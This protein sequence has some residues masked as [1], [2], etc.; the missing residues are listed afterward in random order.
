LSTHKSAEKRARQNEKNRVRNRSWRSKIKTASRKIEKAIADKNIESL[1]SLYHDFISTVDKAV[2]K[3]VLHKNTGSRKK[4]R[5]A[6]KII[7]LKS[8]SSTAS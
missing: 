2:S 4:S 6:S 7:R 3:G 1:D 8:S 5:I